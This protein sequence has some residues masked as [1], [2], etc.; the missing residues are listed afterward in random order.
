MNAFLLAIV[1]HLA[2]AFAFLID[3]ILL[4][5]AL[6]RSGT[7]AALIGMLSFVTLIAVPWIREWPRADAWPFIIGFGGVFVLALWAFFEALQR[8][9]ASRVVPIVG[10]LIPLFTLA[11][12][13]IFFHER[14][15]NRSLAGF[16][17]LV[18]A[19]LLLTYGKGKKS[20]A[21]KT[22]GI[23][24][25][26]AFLFAT[27][28]VSGKAAFERGDVLSV[29]VA[30]RL[31][32]GIVGVCL[33]LTVPGV[34][35]EIQKLATSRRQRTNGSRQPVGLVL[36]GQLLGAVGFLCVNAAL[37]YGSASI[38]NALQAVQYGAIALVAWLGG[39]RM[40]RALHEERTREIVVVKS[41]AIVSV[42]IGLWLI[43]VPV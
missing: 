30:S 1:G 11:G 14:L 35:H 3:K 6:K 28:S 20:I 12:T 10:S 8:S 41:T 18:F 31:I 19:T 24:V 40:A 43:G 26:S 33:A 16:A 39:D 9:E 7:Y 34:F 29:F 15:S 23:A 25:V 22:I 2:N 5:S 13:M 37:A 27:A 32:A 38:V 36:C 17:L 42:A 21:S 4:T